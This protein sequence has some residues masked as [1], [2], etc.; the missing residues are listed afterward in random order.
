MDK[1]NNPGRRERAVNDARV[2]FY[3]IYRQVRERLSWNER[4]N[5]AGYNGRGNWS[6]LFPAQTLRSIGGKSHRLSMAAFRCAVAYRR[7][8]RHAEN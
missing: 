4:R 7:N 3:L 5:A 8:C 1:N 2:W 6:I